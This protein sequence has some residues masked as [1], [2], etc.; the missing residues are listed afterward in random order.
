MFTFSGFKKLTFA[1]AWK[2]NP[3]SAIISS[4]YASF[5]PCARADVA[6]INQALHP[7]RSHWKRLSLRDQCNDSCYVPRLCKT[8]LLSTVALIFHTL[9]ALL[10]SKHYRISPTNRSVCNA[11][12][13]PRTER[14]NTNTRIV[15]PLII[16][17]G[18]ATLLLIRKWP[19]I[20]DQYFICRLISPFETVSQAS[21]LITTARE[22]DKSQQHNGDLRKSGD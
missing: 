5:L 21:S 12:Q 14:F 15:T 16:T 17:S 3:P 8:V 7:N 19:I 2:P 9:Y 6:S 1:L 10:F 11:N 13:K 18:C 20:C 4:I 22:Y